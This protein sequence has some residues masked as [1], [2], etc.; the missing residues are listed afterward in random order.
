MAVQ[1]REILQDAAPPQS[2]EHPHID[3]VLGV[4]GGEPKIAGTGIAVW[5]IAGWHCMDMGL[6]EILVMYPHLTAA[7]VYD[8]LSYYYDHKAEVDE[9]RFQNTEEYWQA[10]MGVEWPP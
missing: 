1:E 5:I 3:R 9:V 8:A 6:D 4:A 10:K 2:L 7:Q